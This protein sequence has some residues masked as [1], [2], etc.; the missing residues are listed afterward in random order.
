MKR[1]R[2]RIEYTTLVAVVF[3]LCRIPLNG[4]LAAADVFGWVA[5]HIVRMR[6]KV[7]LSNLRIA[8]P[9]MAE[10]ERKAIA[11]RTYRNFAKMVFEYSRFPVLNKETILSLC[12]MEGREHVDWALQHGKGAVLV[13]GHFGNWE[14]MGAAFAQMGYPIHFLVGE[15]HNRLVDDTMN[16][17]RELMGIGII[18]MG[19]A[20]RGV[21]RTLRNNAFVALLSDQDAGK[22][23]VFVDFF[24]RKSS[25]HQG[26]AVFALRMGAPIL[27]L[28][29]IRLPGGKMRIRIELLRFEDLKEVTEENIRKVTQAYTGLLEKA[30]REHPDHWFWMH[31]R[32]KSRPPESNPNPAP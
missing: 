10:S 29:A 32:W 4:V 22:E 9:E 26:P 1:I 5:F 12:S 28:S 27:F 15:Q 11:A 13:A 30:V 21:I 19:V 31:R 16:R 8:F 3:V 7:T 14:L 24:G 17:N 23:G 2:H 6:R 18:R 20:V 25:T